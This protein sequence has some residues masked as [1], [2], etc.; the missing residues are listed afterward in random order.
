MS[1]TAVSTE[2]QH[3]RLITGLTGGRDMRV[4]RGQRVRIR[5]LATG[6]IQDRVS[7]IPGL[8]VIP[9]G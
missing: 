8:V 6:I 2:P 3:S 4:I 1:R 9:L 5:E 7:L